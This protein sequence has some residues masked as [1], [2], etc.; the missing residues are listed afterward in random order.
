MDLAGKPLKVEVG[1]VAAQANGAVL[2][3]YGDTTVLSTATA[4][5]EPREGVDFFPLSVEFEEKYYAIG[6]IPGGFNKR[7]GKAS[8]NAVLTDRV[9]DRPMRPLFPKDLRNDVT[10]DNLVLSVDP[11]CR[12]ELVAM[13][14]T[15]MATCI[16]DIPFDGP[17]A[18]TQVGMKDGRFIINPSQKDWDTGDLQLTVAST[19]EKVIMIEAGA[20]LISDQTM[21]D[22]IYTADDVNKKIIDLIDQ[23]VSEVGKEKFEYQSFA[24][25]EHML[26]DIE[27]IVTP[28]EMEEAVFVNDKQ[29]REA[30]VA[31]VTDKLT[32]A[33]ADNEEYLT[34]LPDAVYQ[35][36]KKTVRKMILKDH[37]RPDGRAIDQ[38]R[39]LSAEVD[40]IPRV[41]GSSMF[42]RGQTQICDIVTLA[43]LSEVQRVEGLDPNITEKRYIHQ[44][45]FPSYSV[46]ETKPSRGPGR[47]EIGHGALAERA[48]KPVIPSVEEFPYAIRAV[49]ETFESNGS[50]SMASTCASCMSLMAAGVPIKDMVAGISCG[51]VTGETDDDY[52]VLTDIQGIEDFFGDMDFKVTGTH[53][54]ISAI[55][56]DIKIHGLTR[57]I[58]EEA[59]RRAHEARNFIMDTC[60][61]KAISKPRDHVAALAPKIS[62]V[63]I[64][65]DKIGDV[66]GQRGK[67]INE[68][69]SRTGAQVDI[70]EDGRVS[71][72]SL[73]ENANAEAIRMVK[74]IVTDFE[75][76]QILKGTVV[77]IKPF[78]AFVEFAPGK[79]GMVHISKIANERIAHVE[80]VLT[81]GDKVTV[82]CL[83]KDKTGRMSF[84]IKDVPKEALKD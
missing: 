11:E 54:G 33:F 51:L 39:P 70:D 84:S 62:F 74:T 41:H 81:L 61:S 52:I 26:E 20:N 19:R 3:S 12:P 49:S 77:S 65:T 28:D 36:Q 71:V 53:D 56:M 46:G 16:S 9:I 31:A 45:N 23:M 64:P 5:K 55:Q 42:T 63:Q 29:T 82:I 58:V 4:S 72:S 14:G 7:E 21:I 35:Y 75:K 76:G 1:K 6:K 59:I 8:E 73:D 38:I 48:L 13:I 66:V 79:E 50:T 25:P 80:D 57:P 69:I 78:G 47:R 60:M 17:C 43:P 83:G 67:T 24:L 2:I 44:Y 10:L 34:H 15:A 37:K 68:I 22:A 27:K 32:E 40:L 30:N 18:M